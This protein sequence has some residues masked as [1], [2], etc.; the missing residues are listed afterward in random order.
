MKLR[1]HNLNEMLAAE[2]ARSREAVPRLPYE[3]PWSYA[4]A[5]KFGGKSAGFE[6]YF[7]MCSSSADLAAPLHALHS[8]WKL[9]KASF[10]VGRCNP[11]VMA[12]AK[13]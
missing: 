6:G 3:S 12:T 1:L 10:A 5:S 7:T 13:M 9:Y 8:L 2:A 11:A 4:T